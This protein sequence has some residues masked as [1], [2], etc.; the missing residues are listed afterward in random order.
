MFETFGKTD[1]GRAPRR[2]RGRGAFTL[3]ELLV[4]LSMI[5]LIAAT[6][7]PSVLKV[8][9]AGTDA[10]AYNVLTAQL[11]AARALAI[12]SGTYAGVHL[13]HADPDATALTDVWFAAVVSYEDVNPDENI[14]D[15]K[16]TLADGYTP[17]R[18]PGSMV[19][20]EIRGTFMNGSDYQGVG[21]D[22]GV[23]D[24]TTFTVVFAPSGA[25]VRQVQMRNITF[26]G[27][28]AIF[29]DADDPGCLWDPDVANDDHDGGDDGESGAIAVVLF[30]YSAFRELAAAQRDEYLKGS[31]Q[32][33]PLNVYTGQPFPREQR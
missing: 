17:R 32:L 28:A 9:A 11:A 13:Q 33:I 27:G 7:I 8:F 5:V 18:L 4:V 1:R 31:G 10:Q 23:E 30:D 20:G 29:D 26:D 19:F 2:R 15:M 12:T 16:F 24:F 14:L 21:S 6:V 3:V 22:G 25:I